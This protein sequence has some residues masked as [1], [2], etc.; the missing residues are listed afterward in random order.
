MV[1]GSLPITAESFSNSLMGQ[2]EERIEQT[3]LEHDLERRGVDGVAAEVAEEVLVLLQHHDLDAGAG[4]EKSEHHPGGAAA[5][6]AATRGDGFSCHA[7]PPA[8]AMAAR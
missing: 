5:G 2:L 7:H 6:D 4:E 8:S 1:T 3:K